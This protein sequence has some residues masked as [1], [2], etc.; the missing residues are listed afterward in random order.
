MKKPTIIEVFAC[1]GHHSHWALID[2]ETGDKVWSEAPEECKA[3]GFPV[4]E[5]LPDKEFLCSSWKECRHKGMVCRFDAPC[6]FK[7]TII[8]K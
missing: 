7:V 8:N 4:E 2:S 5:V 1:N 3:M 6:D